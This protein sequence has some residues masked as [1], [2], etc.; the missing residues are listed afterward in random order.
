[1]KNHWNILLLYWSFKRQTKNMVMRI[2]G[3]SVS[4]SKFLT[5]RSGVL[6]LFFMEAWLVMKRMACLTTS[7]RQTENTVGM[8]I[9]F[10]TLTSFTKSLIWVLVLE[11]GRWRGSIGYIVSMHI[12]R[13]VNTHNL[14]I[15]MVK[16][17]WT[18]RKKNECWAR[19]C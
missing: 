8:S 18:Q 17:I 19:H 1:M 5:P 11:P 6:L 7:S 2:K 3:A 14:S 4:F 10:L 16:F 9:K 12:C 15:L 13:Y